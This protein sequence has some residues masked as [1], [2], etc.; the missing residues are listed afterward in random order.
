MA[1]E[2]QDLQVRSDGNRKVYVVNDHDKPYKEM[3]RGTMITIPPNGIK[4]YVMPFLTA[5]RFLGQPVT[6]NKIGFNMK[7]DGSYVEGYMPKALRIIEFSDEERAA[8]DPKAIASAK[9]AERRV[10]LRCTLCGTQTESEKE[11]TNHVSDM[12]PGAEP[13]KEE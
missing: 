8:Q 3:F 12:H 11:L 10:A 1:V 4:E 6:P 2:P 5:R 7:P 13:V 9:E